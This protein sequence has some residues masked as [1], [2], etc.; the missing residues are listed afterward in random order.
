MK[1]GMIIIN[2]ENPEWG[3]WVVLYEEVKGMWV[4]RGRSGTTCIAESE[5][6]RFWQEVTAI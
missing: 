1:S 3:T 2:R 6:R 4:I 5:F